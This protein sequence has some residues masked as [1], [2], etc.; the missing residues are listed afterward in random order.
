MTEPF[1]APAL[2]EPYLNVTTSA[3][4]VL[5][6]WTLSLAMANDT[7][8]G[9]LSQ[10]E[11]HYDTFIVCPRDFALGFIIIIFFRLKK[12]LHKSQVPA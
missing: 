2:F 11:T 9:G 4:P 6:E 10:L 3:G 1:I 8:N 5:D 12:T 7:A